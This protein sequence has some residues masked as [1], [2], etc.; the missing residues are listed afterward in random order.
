M[1]RLICRSE[2]NE[3][4]N[5]SLLGR[6][7]AKASVKRFYYRFKWP[8]SNK[9]AALVLVMVTLVHTF[10]PTVVVSVA[11]FSDKDHHILFGIYSGCSIFFYLF[12]PITGLYADIKFGRYKTGIT[13]LA[14]SLCTCLFI[15]VGTLLYRLEICER[16]GFILFCMGFIVGNFARTS[17]IIVM[18]S[19]G[20][21]QLLGASG[22]ELSSFMQ[23]FYLCFVA[24]WS[25]SV[26]I[27]CSLE[28]IN[29]SIFVIYTAHLCCIMI[30]LI[31][32]LSFRVSMIS[33]PQVKMN[34]VSLIVKVMKYARN[35]RFPRNRSALTYWEEDYPSR[36]D[37]AKEKYGGPFTE[38]Q[39]Q[40]VKTLLRI[41][42]LIVCMLMFFIMADGYHFLPQPLENEY[43]DCLLS[44]VF[45]I[46]CTIMVITILLH[47]IVLY[48]ILYK[49]YP[50]ML[51][52]IGFGIF[53]CLLAQGTWVAI[54]VISPTTRDDCVLGN[55]YNNTYYWDI[56]D[57]WMMIPKIITGLGFGTVAPTTLEFAF[58]Q[59]PYSMRGVIVGIWF[60]TTGFLK[61]VGFTMFYPFKLIGDGLHPPCEF[62]LFI[63]KFSIIGLS[64]IFF[65]CLSF[66]YKLRF[67]GERFDQHQTVEK[68]YT[69]YLEHE[70][71]KASVD[72]N[73]SFVEEKHFQIQ[74]GSGL[75]AFTS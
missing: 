28:D 47:Q 57:S 16:F 64:L 23:W 44:S 69:K 41:V 54:D 11:G 25:V 52:K 66:W 13:S 5:T 8:V 14:V 7:S 74:S 73:D 35:N 59:A 27:I 43:A 6:N 62:Y 32:L 72:F 45:F 34:P 51:Q 38:E 10:D 48:P 33:E 42:P 1:W 36:L 19:F 31:I 65:V 3:N 60:M 30:A 17:F 50:S 63:S 40:D 67:R 29:Y 61:T 39:V 12:Y 49:W 24:G 58:A 55:L 20:V 56:Q 15:I 37:L 9:C 22:E 4:E 26:P 68:F 18:L 46:N 53:L 2:N 75:Y 70:E 21:D 71:E